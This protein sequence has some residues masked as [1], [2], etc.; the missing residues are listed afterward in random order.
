[1]VS[2]RGAKTENQAASSAL[3]PARSSRGAT[4]TRPIYAWRRGIKTI[5]YVRL[6]QLALEGTPNGRLRV[7][8]PVMMA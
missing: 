1:M 8:R 3:C 6:R 5:Y 7:L 4:S 2:S